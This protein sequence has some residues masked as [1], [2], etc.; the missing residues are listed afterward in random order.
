MHP[1]LQFSKLSLQW[2]CSQEPT[3]SGS[4]RVIFLHASLRLTNAHIVLILLFPA[5]TD[6]THRPARVAPASNW[7]Q[8]TRILFFAFSYIKAVIGCTSVFMIQEHFLCR[9]HMVLNIPHQIHYHCCLL[10]L[11]NNYYC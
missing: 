6:T 8:R 7:H 9:H 1:V 5:C 4:V 3:N 10:I 2:S 11:W